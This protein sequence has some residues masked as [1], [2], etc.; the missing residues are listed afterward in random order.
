[1]IS[2][3]YIFCRFLSPEN[4][5][6]RNAKI[7]ILKENSIKYAFANGEFYTPD[8]T[9]SFKGNNT[10]VSECQLCSTHTSIRGSI[11]NPSNFKIH[12]E[13]SSNIHIIFNFLPFDITLIIN[14]YNTVHM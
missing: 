10:I 11:K 4:S 2:Y 14:S 9:N 3:L 8:Y 7:A 12:I 5:P 13:V 1:M 6:E